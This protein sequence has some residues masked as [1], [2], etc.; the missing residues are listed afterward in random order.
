MAS[1]L[2]IRGG[3]G[4]PRDVL[5][6]A[7]GGLD[8]PR[9]GS[10]SAAASLASGSAMAATLRKIS[11]MPLL[12]PL[13]ARSAHCGPHSYS[14]WYE[15]LSTALLIRPGVGA[16]AAGAVTLERDGTPPRGRAAGAV[17]GLGGVEEHVDDGVAVV[18][19]RRADQLAVVAAAHLGRLALE[20]GLAAA[21]EGLHKRPSF[22]RCRHGL[23]R[24]WYCRGPEAVVTVR[25][26][27]RMKS[28]VSHTHGQQQ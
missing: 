8:V 13:A 11:P 24:T 5:G 12:K 7:L 4:L 3:D 21:V 27:T 16:P 18:A 28:C 14:S 22:S 6:A 17:G 10:G 25:V 23:P 19:E 9:P 2:G 1:A 15:V 26:S 20:R